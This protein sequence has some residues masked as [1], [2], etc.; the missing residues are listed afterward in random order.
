MTAKDLMNQ[1]TFKGIYV[2]FKKYIW[3]PGK[4]SILGAHSAHTMTLSKNT[5]KVTKTDYVWFKFYRSDVVIT[6]K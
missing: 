3:T 6:V 4:W 5:H 2:I 1:V